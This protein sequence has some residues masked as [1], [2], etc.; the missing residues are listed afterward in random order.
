MAKKIIQLSVQ[1]M[2]LGTLAQQYFLTDT[3]TNGKKAFISSCFWWQV[4][5][6]VKHQTEGKTLRTVYMK[7]RYQW[8]EMEV[9]L[10]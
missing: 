3:Q 10:K 7:R 4:I 5:L 9:D 1:S 2:C 6:A 8:F